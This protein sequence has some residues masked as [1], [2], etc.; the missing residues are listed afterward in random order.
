MNI[1]DFPAPS[2]TIQP[3][4]T[5]SPQMAAKIALAF[6][7]STAGVYYVGSGRKEQSL[8]KMI[9][10]AVLVLAALFFF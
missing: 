1:K 3:V 7:L 10:G 4:F 9:L 5:L 2:E 6:L 8:Q